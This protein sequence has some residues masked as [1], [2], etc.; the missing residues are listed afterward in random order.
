M[1]RAGDLRGAVRI[2]LDLR[3]VVGAQY[4]AE[5]SVTQ[6]V[7]L[8]LDR[9]EALL[10]EPRERSLLPEPGTEGAEVSPALE[11]GLRKLRAC[12][13]LAGAPTGTPR[14]GAPLRSPPYGAAPTLDLSE[15]D[16]ETHLRAARAMTA[17][18]QYRAAV[19]AARRAHDLAESRHTAR[20]RLDAYEALALLRLQVGDTPGAVE[21][22]RRALILAHG[23]EALASRIQMAR[24]L[25]QAHHLEEA[26]GIL[27]EAAFEAARDPKLAPE[28][29]EARA[30]LALRL[31]APGRAIEQLDLALDLH[32]ERYGRGHPST[33]AV[34]QLRGNAFRLAGDLPA[35]K[36]EYNNAF[37]I[38]RKV[39]GL[40]H[41]ETA[42]SLNALGVLQSDFRDWEAADRTFA[43]ALASL[44]EEF[45]V[46]HP[47]VIVVRANR[48]LVAWG[49]SES[50]AAATDYAAVVNALAQAHGEDHPNVSD[51]RRNLARMEEKLGRSEQAESLL[52]LALSAQLRALGAGHPALAPTRVSRGRFFAR[53]GRL[54]EAEAELEDAIAVL[55]EHYG[56]EHP[57]VARARSLLSR[58]AT[59]KGEREVAWAE[60]Q[61]AARVFSL[62]LS[63][64]FDAMPDRERALLAR[65]STQV[66]GALLSAR[67]VAPRDVYVEMIP[68]RDSVLRSI[69]ATRGAA[70]DANEA[71]RASLVRLEE[72]RARYVAAILSE[73]P[74]AAERARKLAREID[75]QE[76]VVSLAQG[77]PR[78]LDASEVI[79][80]ACTHLPADASLIEFVLYDRIELGA[81]GRV[82]PSYAAMIVRPQPRAGGVP[83]CSVSRV[84]LGD[85]ARIEA[86]AD[87]FARAMR[88]QRSDA[89]AERKLLGELLLNPIRTKLAGSSRWLVIPDAALWGV[90]FPAL[91]DPE[92]PDHYLAQRV[93]SGTLTSI[94][95]LAEF[96][97]ADEE[98]RTLAGALLFGA[99]DFGSAAK[100][101]SGPVVLTSAGPC[102]LAPFE[103]LPAT[104]LEIREIRAILP[105]PR[106][107]LGRDATKARFH[108]EL[109]YRPSILHLATHAYFAAV[110]GCEGREAEQAIGEERP[111][112]DTRPVS[113]NPL[114]L[115]GI[116]FAG[117]NE[118][119]RIAEGEAA[120]RASGILTAYEAA[121]LDLSAS[122]LVVLSACDTGAGL[123]RR[124][125]EIQGLRW[126]FRAAGAGSLVTSLW[127]SNDVVTRKLMA[128]FYGAL[129]SGDLP[130][131]LFLGAEALRRA[132]LAR[133]ESETRLGI[134][135]PLHW[136]NFSFS[137]VY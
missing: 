60:A 62:Y 97:S 134:K 84:E 16:F 23:K 14:R 15:G 70:R 19:V 106:V 114:M 130:D 69:A 133:V 58:V 128:S 48:A 91:P 53:A 115:S 122:R 42:R 76:T 25:A 78:A 127:R 41:P 88:D 113:P 27:Q 22:A 92:N 83:H 30:D 59:R 67:G 3:S 131:D 44:V 2:L 5:H 77:S 36:L 109:A 105:E 50:P 100:E 56:D 86:A 75:A 74:R 21:A 43:Q 73:S 31:G 95:E 90:S 47:E 120:E 129:G 12:S 123:H 111:V 55:I 13:S 17:K 20:E 80:R 33:A 112:S 103:P 38:R 93:T 104:A 116:V 10:G 66:M 99:P 125:Q 26:R 117:A 98:S 94:H 18:G 46:N 110:D 96:D 121:G 87:G 64:S 4:G 11:R 72:L 85:A 37:E 7:E 126:G 79:H 102:R 81:P 28:L 68:Q 24:L 35:A 108:S 32:I 63:R 132:Q 65:D 54:D 82:V 61:E 52:D 118:S 136:A 34:H 71:S 89:P 29:A 137:G 101:G 40:A 107:V 39:L 57:L 8:S 135:K 45:G 49:A 9:V 124:G 119:A 51:A 6:I 1:C